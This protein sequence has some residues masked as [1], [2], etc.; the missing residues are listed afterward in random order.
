MPTPSTTKWPKPKNEDEWEDM[1]LDAIRIRWNDPNAERFGRRGQGQDGVDIFGHNKQG[2]VAAQVKNKNTISKKI[3]CD[4][5]LDIVNSK[6][7]VNE[8]YFI[9][10]GDRDTKLQNLVREISSLQKLKDSFPVFI[11]F[12]ED[13]VQEL[14]K[15]NKLIKKYWSAFLVG[16]SKLFEKKTILNADSAID[17]LYNLK[18]FNELSEL[19]LRLSDGKVNLNFRIEQIPDLKSDIGCIERSWQIAIAENHENH[20]V[21]LWRIAIDIDDN[22]MKYYNCPE[23]EWIPYEE[24][25]ESYGL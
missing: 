13:I 11:L 15:D 14:S 16:V 24:W 25:I 7:N 22:S 12:F 1:V 4:T 23:D 6:Y 20:I 19:I 9:I 5:I 8:L 21:T 3:I 2:C 10:S 17:E 18:E